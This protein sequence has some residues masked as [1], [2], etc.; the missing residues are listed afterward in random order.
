M[1]FN[2]LFCIISLLL[3][4]QAQAEPVSTGFFNHTAIGGMDTVAYHSGDVKKSHKAIE[5]DKKFEV[6]YL[7]AN[8]RFISKESADKFAAT[9]AAFIPMYNGHCAN[10]LSMGK[11]LVPTDGTFW[12]FFGDK[13]YL[14]YDEEGHQ[15]W[16][17]GN[18]QSYKQSADNAWFEILKNK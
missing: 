5:G 13:L 12:E 17:K 8:W 7:G 16:L 1:R 3:I 10:A 18:W 14:F 2:F 6:K 11:G 4:T 9:P 15:R